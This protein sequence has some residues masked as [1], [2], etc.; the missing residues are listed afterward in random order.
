MPRARAKIRKHLGK[1]NPKIDIMDEYE[2]AD[3]DRDEQEAGLKRRERRWKEIELVQKQERQLQKKAINNAEKM[4][5][6]V[7]GVQLTPLQEAWL[8]CDYLLFNI[9]E[10][11]AYEFMEWQRLNDPGVYRHLYRKFMSKYMMAN[12]QIYADYFA[13]GGKAPKLISLGDVVQKYKKYKGI[14]TK[15]KIVHKGEEEHEL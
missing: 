12:A 3:I 13:K 7:K 1:K 4:E 10:L 8:R 9:M 6:G 14:K 5:R 11:K 2:W 15:I